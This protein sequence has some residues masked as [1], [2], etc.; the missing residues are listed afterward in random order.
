MQLTHPVKGLE[1]MPQ[2]KITVKK[3]MIVYV[4]INYPLST[5]SP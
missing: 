4:E 1:L 5:H 3:H 2:S